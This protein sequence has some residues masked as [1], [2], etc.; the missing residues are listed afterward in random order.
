MSATTSPK[1]IEEMTELEKL[2]A[3]LEYNFLG[4]GIEERMEAAYDACSRL[5]RIPTTDHEAQERIMRDLLGACGERLFIQPGFY[6]TNGKNIRVGED[7]LMNVNLVILDIAP[8]TIGDYCMIGPNVLITTVGHPLS[9]KKRREKKAVSAPVVIGDDVWIGGHSTILPGVTIGDNVV[10]A[11]GAVVTK[12]VPSNC[13][14]GG[15]PASVIRVLEND[16]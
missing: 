3:G 1:P 2:D 14:V 4:E 9:P 15:V 6:C 10:I 5:N 12:D 11:A 7:F 16:L 13:L 8:V